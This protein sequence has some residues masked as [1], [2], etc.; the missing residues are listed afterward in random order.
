MENRFFLFVDQDSVGPIPDALSIADRATSTLSRVPPFITPSF[1]L[2]RI[3]LFAAFFL[4]AG[5]GW[6]AFFFVPPVFDSSLSLIAPFGRTVSIFESSR[7]FFSAL[8]M[9]EP[10]PVN[11]PFWAASFDPSHRRIFLP[12]LQGHQAPRR[13]FARDLPSSLGSPFALPSDLGCELFLNG[14]RGF[15]TSFSERK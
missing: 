13:T 3:L 11:A 15:L 2:S 5:F 10:F 8:G 12:F 4:E 9:D 7:L 14:V 1:A 6:A